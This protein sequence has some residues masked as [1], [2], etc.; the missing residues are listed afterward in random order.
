MVSPGQITNSDR[1][2]GRIKFP[3]KSYTYLH[4]S[5]PCNFWSSVRV[6]VLHFSCL[7]L[8]TLQMQSNTTS[9]CENIPA[10]EE[11][12]IAFVQTIEMIQEELNFVSVTIENPGTAA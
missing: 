10:M 9:K 8:K 7:L 6:T 4:A 1:V 2:S 3:N 12:S 5:P 11:A